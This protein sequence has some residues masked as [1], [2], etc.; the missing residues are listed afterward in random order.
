MR[1]RDP[2]GEGKKHLY[3]NIVPFVW[4]LS[5]SFGIALALF[6]AMLLHELWYGRRQEVGIRR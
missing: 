1:R 5:E 2:S 4:H 6:G 3:D